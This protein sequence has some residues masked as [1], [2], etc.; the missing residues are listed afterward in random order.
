MTKKRIIDKRIKEKFMMDDEYMNGMAKLC[1]WQATITYL[2]LCRH[3][4]KNQECFPSIKLIAEENK[5]SRPTIIKGL[6]MLEK[7]S[8]I[9][10]QKKRNKRGIWLNNSYT[11]LDKSVW[12]YIQVNEIDMDIQVNENTYPSKRGLP[13]QVNEVYTKETHKQGNT[14]K[15]THLLQPQVVEVEKEISLKDLSLEKQ[16]GELIN[17]F[18]YC[19]P[20]YKS[21]FKRKP[22]REAVKRLLDITNL[23]TLTSVIQK[24]PVINKQPYFPT[25]TTPYMLCEKWANLES[26]IIREKEKQDSNKII[27]I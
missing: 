18:K 23:E 26:A 24:L 25:I 9:T 8:V 1:G 22:Q 7:R 21:L 20:N 4:N 5:V 14:Y 17:M 12:N 27:E 15:E 19:N 6:Q 10:I 3:V 11:L 2:S 13:T 16:V